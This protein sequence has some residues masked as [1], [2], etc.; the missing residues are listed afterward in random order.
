MRRPSALVAGGH[1]S[2]QGPRPGG[3]GLSQGRRQQALS[4]SASGRPTEFS[5]WAPPFVAEVW[6]GGCGAPVLA[7]LVVPSAASAPAP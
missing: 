5:A 3:A 6:R 7:L 4:P 1:E 2:G